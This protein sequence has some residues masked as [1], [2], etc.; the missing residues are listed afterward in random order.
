[1]PGFSLTKGTETCDFDIAGTVSQGGSRIGSWA[2]DKS[3]N[4]V[5]NKD[6]GGQDVYNVAWQFNQDNQLTISSGGQEVFNFNHLTG[7]R[8]LYFT[9]NAVLK[10]R[11]NQNNTFGFD[12]H[13]EWDLD[14]SHNLTITIGGVKST[15]DGFIQDPRSRFMYHFFNKQNLLQE[16][17]LG[18]IGAWQ[19][20]NDNGVPKMQFQ[21][22][23]EDGSMDT[24]VLPQVS[25]SIAASTSSCINIISKITRLRFS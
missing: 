23:R 25:W 18:F 14:D 9:Q 24:F 12:L 8:P 5:V 16:S 7:V 19:F 6:A 4:I 21:Y 2:T 1:M 15:I 13:G 3:N 10:V 11:P 17:I 22:Q 20:V